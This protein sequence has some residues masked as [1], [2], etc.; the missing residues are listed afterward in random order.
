VSMPR[1]NIGRTLASEQNLAKRVAHE[2]HKHGWGYESLAKRMS[3]V[4]CPIAASGLFKLEQRGRRITADE[5]VAFA[6]VFDLSFDELFQPVDLAIDARGEE[7]VRKWGQHRAY[8][9]HAAIPAV[10]RAEDEMR[11]YYAGNPAARASME[12]LTVAVLSAEEAPAPAKE[13]YRIL[14]GKTTRRTQP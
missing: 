11:D 7:L 12:A 6:K 3:E 1:P 5:V 14:A 2:R 10:E 4:G 8:L 13:A 9:R